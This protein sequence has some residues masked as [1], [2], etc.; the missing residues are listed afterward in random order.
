MKQTNPIL[1]SPRVWE[2]DACRGFRILTVLALHLYATVDEFCIDG[3]YH[4]DS[5]RYVNLTDPLHIW[6]D[7][8]AD[9]VIYRSFLPE[10]I[11]NAW[12]YF[13]I[14]ILFIICGISCTFT[15]DPWRRIL[16][17]YAAGFFISAFTFGLYLFTGLENCFIRFGAIFCYAACLTIYHAFLEKKS[18]RFLI[19][20]A[21]PC[22]IAGYYIMFHPIYSYYPLLYPFGIREYGVKASEYFPIFPYLGWVLLGV[23]FGR[24]F[25]PERK[26]LLPFPKL[27]MI[28][29]PL[30]W[31][32]RHSGAVYLA[33]IVIYPVV[34]LAIGYLFDLL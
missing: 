8:G 32:G 23:V 12:C 4:I 33:H 22:L 28:S 16:K 7:W 3:Y 10:G 19:L 6:F 14:A 15:K 1:T 17:L 26:S 9:G 30:Q 29:R 25:Y 31:A 13:G 20:L 2:I 11:L 5:Y 34:F 27:E 21:V 24:R 18:D